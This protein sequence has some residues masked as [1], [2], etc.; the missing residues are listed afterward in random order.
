VIGRGGAFAEGG[1]ISSA[2]SAFAA[3][4]SESV[5]HSE[6]CTEPGGYLSS[7]GPLLDPTTSK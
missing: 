1:H 5:Q 7:L 4:F 3:R 6:R 2:P